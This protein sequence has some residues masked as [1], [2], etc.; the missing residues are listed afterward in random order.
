MANRAAEYRDASNGSFEGALQPRDQ[1]VSEEDGS[2]FSLRALTCG[3][4]SRVV[5]E[6]KGAVVPRIIQIARISLLL[7]ATW[8]IGCSSAVQEFTG[9][10]VA[11][12]DGDTITVL[13][14]RTQVRIRLDGIDCPESR[15]AFGRRA[16][17][18]TSQLAFGNVVTIRPRNKDRY[19]RTVAEIVLPDGRNL[20]HELVQAGFAWW[21][22][23]YA[24][25][26][27]ELAR[28]EAKAQAAKRGLWS[29]LDPVPPWDW[30][31]ARAAASSNKSGAVTGSR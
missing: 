19:G 23:K 22:R 2:R 30:R 18:F 28:L 14:D 6:G 15:Q 3:K 29:D 24:P 7:T 31:S 27:A 25:H 1:T 9:K 16:K 5:A 10:V 13:R 17:S 8:W 4:S 11:V 26:D 21:L 20:N 12:A